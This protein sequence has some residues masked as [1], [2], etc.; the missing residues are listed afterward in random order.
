MSDSMQTPTMNGS[1]PSSKV[2]FTYTSTYPTGG[3]TCAYHGRRYMA[4]SDKHF[5][6]NHSSARITA[7]TCYVGHLLANQALYFPRVCPYFEPI[8]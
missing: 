3:R 1:P 7:V 8:K 2:G 6:C 5:V 4:L